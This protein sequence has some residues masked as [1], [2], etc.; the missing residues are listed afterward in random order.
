MCSISGVISVG[1]QLQRE[2]L[3]SLLEKTNSA[4]RHRGP[5][6]RGIYLEPIENGLVG[7]ANT[8][9]AIIDLSVAGHQPM[10]DSEAGLTITYNGEIY[11]FRELRQE[12]GDAFGPWRSHTDTEV[13][14]RAYRRWGVKAFAKLR[15]MFAI[16]IW[17]AGQAEL[18]LAR[19]PFG[20]KPLYYSAKNPQRPTSNV[21]R[22]RG[23][24]AHWTLDLGHAFVFASEVRALLATG[25]LGPK[26]SREGLAS[27]LEYG[28]VQA[29]TT[30]I[31]GVLSLLPGHFLR[32]RSTAA[33]LRVEGASYESEFSSAR[34]NGQH[35][36]PN[37]DEAVKVLRQKLE[38]SVRL[39][40]VSDVPLG[41][42][43]S[44][45]MDSSAL[46]ALMSRATSEKAK[47]FSVVFDE[48]QFSESTHS[49]LVAREF[50][51]DHREIHLTEDQLLGMLPEALSAMDQP[52]MDGVNTFVVSKAVKDQGFVVALSGLGGDELFAGY[53]TFR[54]AIRSKRLQSVPHVLRRPASRIGTFFS[55]SARHKKLWR[56]VASDG[57]P[58]AA[59][60]VARQLFA[61]DQVCSIAN[62][63]L[64]S[65]PA[66]RSDRPGL[67]NANPEDADGRDTE[68]KKDGQSSNA[69]LNSH[70]DAVNEISLLELQGYMSNTL[71][72]DTD[73]MSMAHSLEVRVPFVDSEIVNYV[74]S[75][76][77]EWK[78]NGSRPK[79]LLAD[80]LAD[81]LPKK[82]LERPKMGFT[83]PFEKWMQSGLRTEIS[84]V[85]QAH[86]GLTRSGLDSEGVR[87]LWRHFLRSPA[88]T[89]WSRPWS[90]YVLAKWCEINGVTN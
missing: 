29:P 75:L 18:V 36:P 54:R 81:L 78:L 39:H 2:Q 32:V 33:T 74:L 60:T 69:P 8:R 1:A 55:R 66:S 38:E 43:L 57:S 51:T 77:G 50:Q 53:S 62:C 59:Y 35:R 24:E 87:S 46:V 25:W 20:I 34:R 83:L 49:R 45:G 82:F 44:G 58:A 9:L 42:F 80:A 19:D 88:S 13:V 70:C 26:L 48:A 47:T 89:G 63:E 23:E 76:P 73:C 5:D 41:V 28:S 22:P 11:N 14:L 16:A 61:P 65:Q 90:L 10:R 17:D 30:I 15:G 64:E 67:R 68:N 79:P 6:D 86:E 27:Y 71:L 52:T 12:I 3:E 21:Q 72:R 37:R 40:L 56:L 85:F 31:D 4:L 7:L 84:E